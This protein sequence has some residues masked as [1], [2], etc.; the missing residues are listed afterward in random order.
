ML[1]R[2][3]PR[4][5][6][7]EWKRRLFHHLRIFLRETTYC[8]LLKT[9]KVLLPLDCNRS[10]FLVYVMGQTWLKYFKLQ[11][12]I[13]VIMCYSSLLCNSWKNVMQCVITTC[14]LF[15]RK[16]VSVWKINTFIKIH[17]KPPVQ[18]TLSNI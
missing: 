18:L 4:R 17:E 15:G 2:L 10:L 1:S 7:L 5:H 8:F 14:T 11:N 3:I 12:K 13:Y 16:K 9:T 6:F